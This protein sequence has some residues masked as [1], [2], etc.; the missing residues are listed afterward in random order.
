[1]ARVKLLTPTEWEGTPRKKGD[2]IDVP[3]EIQRLNDG[4]MIPTDEPLTKT[5]K[6][7]DQ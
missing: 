5:E 1:M 3:D 2:V 4:W 7:T 6:K